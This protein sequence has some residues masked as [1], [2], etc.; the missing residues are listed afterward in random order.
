MYEISQNDAYHLH[1]TLSRNKRHFAVM[2]RIVVYE[3]SHCV[4]VL[5]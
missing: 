5:I 3:G 2:N 1:H 4:I